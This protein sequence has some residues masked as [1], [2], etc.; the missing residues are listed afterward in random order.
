MKTLTF[1]IRLKRSYDAY[2]KELDR[3]EKEPWPE[4]YR[5]LRSLGFFAFIEEVVTACSM[6]PR[7]MDACRQNLEDLSFGIMNEYGIGRFHLSHLDRDRL[8]HLILMA[9][10]DVIDSLEGHRYYFEPHQMPRGKE[11]DPY[12]ASDLT[13]VAELSKINDF[14]FMVE[15]HESHFDDLNDFPKNVGLATR[16]SNRSY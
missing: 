5:F 3:A 1:V 7:S 12:Y 16:L 2:V 14:T 15:I 13:A 4:Y 11:D 8:R 10:N 9:G 6:F